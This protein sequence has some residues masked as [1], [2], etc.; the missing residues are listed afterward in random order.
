M[1]TRRVQTLSFFGLFVVLFLFVARILSPFFTV[2]LWST[3]LYVLFSPLYSRLTSRLGHERRSHRALRTTIAALFS[4]GSVVVIVVPLAFVSVQLFRQLSS[5]LSVLLRYLESNPEF[6]DRVLDRI[7]R[8]IRDASLG[9]AEF[10]RASVRSQ[11]LGLISGS[12][13][14]FVK[15]G[16]DTL[17]GLGSFVI[18]LVF[19]IFTLYFFYVDGA[20]LLSL[21]VRAFPI[22]TEY[23]KELVRKFGEI[24]RNLFL[25]YIL[26][27]LFQA[28]VAFVL[29]TL[30]SVR[31]A[32]LFSVLV[33]FASFIPIF[34]AGTVWGPLGIA[35][36]VSGDIWGG[37]LFL[38]L[39]GVLISTLDNFLRPFFLK[40]RIKLHP[41]IIFFSILGGLALFG[42]NGLILGPVVVI[43]FLTVLD[44]FLIE[45]GLSLPA[46]N[47]SGE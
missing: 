36:I 21:V 28:A 3:L 33:M 1:E 44:F 30:F 32:L 24:T 40:D 16:T 31:E 5:I 38:V 17:F 2:I 43:F 25:G 29:F 13:K 23:M 45:H 7:T 41:L 22:R 34:G 20:Y 12:F 10:D 26:V 6:L 46:A 14:T 19:M 42:F 15:F 27:A 37:L 47:D 8:L 35:R 9:L 18:G 4:M 11:I 39:C